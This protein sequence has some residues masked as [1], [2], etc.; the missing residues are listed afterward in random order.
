MVWLTYWYWNPTYFLLSQKFQYVGASSWCS[1]PRFND[2]GSCEAPPTSLLASK[3]TAG[4]RGQLLVRFPSKQKKYFEKK[5]LRHNVY[6]SCLYRRGT[7]K[8]T[9][10][11][12]KIIRKK[13][14]LV[15][16]ES[17]EESCKAMQGMSA[18]FLSFLFMPRLSPSASF[19]LPFFLSTSYFSLSSLLPAFRLLS[20]LL[21]VCFRFPPFPFHFLL[22]PSVLFPFILFSA[23]CSLIF[24]LFSFSCYLVCS[25]FS[26]FQFLPFPIL[27]LP[28]FRVSLRP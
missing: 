13:S 3:A 10:T 17:C 21:S 16:V 8:C 14:I 19:C 25:F 27:L 9:W 1:L 15:Q 4:S 11:L 24:P 18:H 20:L 6:F 23:P 28:A 5:L 2:G 22:L 7:Q 26:P 12:I